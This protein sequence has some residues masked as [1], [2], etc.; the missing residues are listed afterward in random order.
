VGEELAKILGS[1]I[2]AFGINLIVVWVL[3][4]VIFKKA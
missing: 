4:W 1:F 3:D 2:A